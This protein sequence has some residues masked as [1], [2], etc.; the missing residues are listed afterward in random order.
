MR[1]MNFLNVLSSS[2]SLFPFY[3]LFC[4]Y[5]TYQYNSFCQISFIRSSFYIFFFFFC[6]NDVSILVLYCFS[7][8]LH[9]SSIIIEILFLIL[10]FLRI[11]NFLPYFFK[12]FFFYL[13]LLKYLCQ[14]YHIKITLV[15]DNFPF[16][17]L[18]FK[19]IYSLYLSLFLY[20]LLSLVTTIILL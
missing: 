14:Y 6:K 7:S 4:F 1:Q 17:F 11:L 13:S 8:F 5:F 10:L 16:I 19:S 12:L 9:F 3:S 2:F 18:Y 20:I 15:T